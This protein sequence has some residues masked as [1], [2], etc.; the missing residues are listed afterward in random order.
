MKANMDVRVRMMKSGVTQYD[1]A[2]TL[3]ITPSWVSRLL[4]SELSTEN[5]QKVMDAITRIETERQSRV[6]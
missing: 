2:D 4:R 6:Q 3:G 1:L 5:T